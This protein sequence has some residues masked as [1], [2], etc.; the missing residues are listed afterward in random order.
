MDMQLCLFSKEVQKKMR[1]NK[2]L[3]IL[4]TSSGRRVE[5]IKHFKNIYSE[6]NIDGMILTADLKENSPAGKVS[7][8]HILV[9]RVDSKEYIE[10]LINICK[11]N[12]ISLVIP[13][14]DTEL[15]IL[16]NHKEDFERMGVTLLISGT[17]THEICNDKILT[18]RFFESNGFDA[19][20][21]YDIEEMLKREKIDKPLLIKPAKGSSGVGVH[22]LNQLEELEFYARNL[23]EPILQE[24]IKGEEYTIDVFTDFDGKILTVVPRLRIETR[25]GEVS[26]GKTVY[27]PILIQKAKE[28]VKAL[29]G[30]IGCI[31]VQCFLTKNNEVKFIEINPRFGGG[32]PL[33]L[34][35]GADYA[36]YL[37]ETLTNKEI[38]FNIDNWID[39]LLMLRYDAA[40]FVNGD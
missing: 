12:Q 16:S 28:V 13:L 22:I 24:L 39:S 4:F 33:S 37:I 40:I 9:P 8:R 29:P 2:P 30:A 1:Q 27:N 25:A 36:K 23:R 21:V 3:N 6:L 11:E 35:A 7:D 10:Y 38:S 14:I 17:R 34:A 31:T 18:A 32:A 26:K 15:I 5:L 19:P 20:R